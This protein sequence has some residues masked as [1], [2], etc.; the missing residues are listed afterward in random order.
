M[1]FD[2]LKD[3]LT[4]HSFDFIEITSHLKWIFTFTDITSHLVKL[5]LILNYLQALETNC[6][7]SQYP[8][9]I[10]YCSLVFSTNY[11]HMAFIFVHRPILLMGTRREIVILFTLKNWDFQLKNLKMDSHWQA[12][13]KCSH[14]KACSHYFLVL[15][16][17]YFSKI[18]Q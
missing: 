17:L 14:R 3:F 8:F 5:S 16:M 12:Y 9:I 6:C 18:Q 1:N 10:I 13:G 2:F 15:S 4:S 11:F 7:W